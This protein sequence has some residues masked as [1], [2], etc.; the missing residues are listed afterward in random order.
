MAIIAT[1]EKR[2]DDRIML[3]IPTA[4]YRYSV[5][6]PKAKPGQNIRLEGE[7]EA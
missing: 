5:V 6:D 3:K 1:A 7:V 2:I 4:N